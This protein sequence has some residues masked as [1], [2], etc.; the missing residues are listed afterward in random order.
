MLR[1]RLTFWVF[2]LFLFTACSEKRV[3]DNPII[4]VEGGQV[5]G[6][7]ATTP[8]VTI[9]KGIPYAAPPTGDNRWREPQPVI[10]WN[11]V[12]M[13]D[14]FG[15]AAMQAT[16]KEGEFYHKEF[17][18]DGDAPYSEDCLTLNVW[19]PAPGKVDAKLPVAMWVHGGAYMSGWGFEKEMDGEAWADRDVILVTI[20]YRLGIFGFLVHPELSKESTNSVAGNYGILDQ[21][22]ALK[23]I[24]NN[25]RQFGGDP[26]NIT[27]F[28]QSAGGGSVK[29]LV[30]SP[31]TKGMI[32]RA[33]IQSAGGL[34]KNG[35]AGMGEGSYE[36]ALASGKAL[37][38]F[39]GYNTLEKMKA[40][41]ANEI[42]ELPFQ[43]AKEGHWAMQ[44]PVIDGYVSKES[45]S[46]ATINGNIADV[47][48]MIGFVSGDMRM[49]DLGSAE[50][51]ADFCLN[52]ADADKNVYAYQFAR[53]L[54]G[55]DAGAYHSSELWY[56]FQTLSRAWRPF[57]EGDYALSNIMVDAWCNF[58]NYGNPNGKGEN[59][60]TPYTNDNKQFMIFNLDKNDKADAQM[61]EVVTPVIK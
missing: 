43:Y 23:W 32:S 24:R 55:D 42:Y 57:T 5:Q 54:P 53:L 56:I 3:N 41:S 10:A 15:N 60:W 20:N 40:A 35:G 4:T 1:T 21:I 59:N 47:P 44:F 36:N 45:F 46:S 27:I 25:I 11:G 16:H 28:G 2:V 19:T 38:D 51:I 52:R 58:A 34:D 22:A 13:A 26:L 49:G 12:K 17:F 8:G 39:G 50:A 7:K 29:T 31:L 37:M 9:Y 33:I 18:S 6:V 14:K 30:S 48:Y 61:G